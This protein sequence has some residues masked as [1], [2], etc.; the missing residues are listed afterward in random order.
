MR[1]L[2]GE[3]VAAIYRGSRPSDHLSVI[4]AETARGYRF[5][6]QPA[7]ARLSGAFAAH[8][9]DGA[10]AT[11]TPLPAVVLAAERH[12][13]GWWRFDRRPHLDDAGRPIGFTDVPDAVW[14]DMYDRG[15]ALVTELDAYAGLLVSLHGTGLRRRRYGLSPTWSDTPSAF[16]GFVDRHEARQRGLLEDLLDAG[17]DR[18]ST[19]D[20]DLLLALHET[21]E[22]SEDAT[23]SRLWRNY[24]LLEAWD[25]LSLAMCRTVSPPATAEVGPVV[26]PGGETTALSLSATDDGSVGMTPYPFDGAPLELSVEARLVEMASVDTEA[27]LV[28]AYERADPQ[29]VSL[30][31]RP[32]D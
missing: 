18:V 9:G 28:A 1:S 24:V 14:I 23:D 26:L 17:S 7:H 20:R 4:V 6:T 10:L 5:I 31:F 32:V 21:G 22:P 25:S 15:I 11:P 13:D 3:Y 30:R 29:R 12:D 27:A 8:W 2:V 16:A 19:A